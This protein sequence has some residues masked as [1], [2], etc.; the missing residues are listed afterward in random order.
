MDGRLHRT[1]PSRLKRKRSGRTVAIVGTGLIG[2]STGLALRRAS[3]T[4]RVIGY[5]R[6]TTA[7]RTARRRGALTSI[8]PSLDAAVSA[9]DIIVLAVPLT[10]VLSILPRVLTTARSGSLVIDVAA[11]KVPV[12]AVAAALLARRS[13]ASFAGGHPL[14][15][16][17]RAGPDAATPDL[18]TGRPFA[19]CIP[20]Q[21]ARASVWRE[22]ASF[23][24]SL[25]ARP[26]RISARDHDRVIAITSALPQVVA[27]ATALAAQGLLKRKTGL[28]G[29]G[30]ESVTR[31]AESP[32]AV[33]ADPLL[34]NKRNVIQALMAVE[35]W[36]RNFRESVKRYDNVQLRQLLHSAAKARR[37]LKSK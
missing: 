2:A 5:D 1:R 34:A 24:R 25:G 23:V 27:S 3:K 19:L 9:A 37:R 18:F 13:V 29:P 15:G 32:A 17:E 30:F 31:L 12:L 6:R 28:T 4:M 36:V 7:A 33:W 20:A 8:A 11:L 26:L 16:R 35:G 10:A 22:A 14:A 21:R